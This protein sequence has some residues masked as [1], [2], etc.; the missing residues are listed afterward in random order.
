VLANPAKLDLFSAI[1]KVGLQY[2]TRTISHSGFSISSFLALLVLH[3]QNVNVKSLLAA[4]YLIFWVDAIEYL[5]VWWHNF[6]ARDT[7]LGWLPHRVGFARRV[8]SSYSSPLNWNFD[9][10]MLGK[11]LI[12]IGCA[13]NILLT[14]LGSGLLE[15]ADKWKGSRKCLR[16]IIG[17]YWSLLG[18]V[19]L[20]IFLVQSLG[21]EV[22][23]L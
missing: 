6:H 12:F 2:R 8:R 7:E 11:S 9:N 14:L 19:V 5:L 4:V 22:N 20:L 16:L 17:L 23:P 15:V 21:L 1:G 3:D 10:A 13:L 18:T